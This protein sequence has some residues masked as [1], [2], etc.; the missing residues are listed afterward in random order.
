MPKKLL[1]T[2]LSTFG[3]STYNVIWQTNSDPLKILSNNCHQLPSNVYMYHW[4]PL[5]ILLGI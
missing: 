5:K 4:L 1:N 2:F 3:N